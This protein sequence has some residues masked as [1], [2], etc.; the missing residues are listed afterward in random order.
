MRNGKIATLP[1]EFR[2]ELSFRMHQGQS[3][4]NLLAWINALH[5]VQER[6]RLASPSPQMKIGYEKR[7]IQA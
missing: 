4:N 2:N 6:I 1:V 7:T 3:T 5:E